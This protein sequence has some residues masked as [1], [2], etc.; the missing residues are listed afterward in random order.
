VHIK[1][2]K[3]H[4]INGL[5]SAG[6]VIA[7]VSPA[8]ADSTADIIDVLV[9]KGVLTEEEGK[10]LLRSRRAEQEAAE[11]KAR[12]NPMMEIGKKGLIVRT[13]D[14]DFVMKFGGR[15]H[16]D[17]TTHSGDDALSGNVRAVDGTNVR[18]ARI[19]IGGTMYRD[20]DYMIEPDFAGDRVALK[21]VFLLYHGFK[22]PLELTVGHQ[23]HAMSMEIQES[24]ND[25]M[26]TERSLNSALT[27]PAFDRAI[28][29]NLK[30]FGKDWNVQSG[31]YGDSIGT[32]ANNQAEGN[33]FGIRGTYAPINE[34][35]RVVHFGINYGY[36]NTSGDNQVNSA[37][38]RFSYRTTNMSNLR[39]I[40]ANVPNLE[41]VSMGILEFSA[42]YGPLS[43]QT[44]FAKTIAMRN[45]AP[46]L[47]FTGYY[48]Q[49]GY[50]LTG[51]SRTYRG[52]DGEFKRLK[53]EKNFDLSKGTWGAWE[54]AVRYDTLDLQDQD[55]AGGTA[56]RVTAA[57]NWYLNEDVR[58][59]ADYSRMFDLGG[60]ALK[61]T[62][63]SYANGID[64]LTIR[65]QWAF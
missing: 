10:N 45:N 1:F 37:S 17:W 36:R 13:P 39:L 6:L 65:T 57:L 38:P 14:N 7:G 28:G 18:R 41:S 31:F 44:E 40:D 26:F 20:F 23:K 33:G 58:L 24:S 21:D 5:L 32:T 30:G 16:A 49:F 46:D 52:S 54:L 8:A 59:M 62:D 64:V 47:H 19:A 53:P 27:V 29:I 42:M 48:V 43:V 12:N 3:T 50:T 15:L 60:G 2:N 22:A 61:H 51:E 11:K 9:K 35:D 25:I 34:S 56:K 4:L 63:G 55:I